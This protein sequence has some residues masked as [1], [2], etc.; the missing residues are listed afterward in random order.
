M[1]GMA[2][3][4]IRGV[5]HAYEL[6]AR[7]LQAEQ[8][9]L[10]FVHGW[11]LSR[12]YWQ[13]VV[14][15]LAPTYPCLTY[16]LR[17]FGESGC[18]PPETA[19]ATYSL[20]AY[21]A[22][23][24]DLLAALK[25]ERAWVIGHSLG[26]SIALWA[27][28]QEPEAIAGTIGVNAG[29]GIYLKEEFERFRA[30]GQRIA[31][32][33]PAWLRY[34]PLLDWLFARAMVAQPLARSWGRQ[35]LLDFVRADTAAALGSLLESTTEEE[36]HRLPQLVAQLAQP[37]YFLA[38]DRDLVMETKY[39]RHLASFHRLFQQGCDNAWELE[40]CGHLAMVE[41]PEAVS[42]AIRTIINRHASCPA[43]VER[44][45]GPA[46]GLH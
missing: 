4:D 34:L 12:R 24:L 6:T 1:N 33:R 5:P 8:P 17:G 15:Q 9:A 3:I 41:Q 43:E 18:S 16:D 23:L 27:A 11:L 38:G 45:V 13:P 42:E 7:S 35:R 10:V 19:G 25:I 14:A 37:A 2:T 21:A 32:T 26:G 22:D 31:R 20:A 44:G 28:A 40:N 46:I 29:G 39:V 36:V 30:A